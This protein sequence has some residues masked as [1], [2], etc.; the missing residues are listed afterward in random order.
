[1]HIFILNFEKCIEF[2]KIIM[3]Q[4]YRN[5]KNSAVS[6]SECV[7]IYALFN[8]KTVDK[9]VYIYKRMENKMYQACLNNAS[10]KRKHE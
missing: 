4:L 7:S 5:G 6:S 1:M 8:D 9:H 2:S 3:V 10:Q